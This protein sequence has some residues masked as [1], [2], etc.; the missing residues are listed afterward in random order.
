MDGQNLLQGGGAGRRGE[1]SSSWGLGAGRGEEVTSCLGRLWGLASFNLTPGIR[2]GVGRM[3]M[4]HPPVNSRRQILL[5]GWAT[6]SF[7]DPPSATRGWAPAQGKREK[8]QLL[9]LGA[10]SYLSFYFTAISPKIRHSIWWNHIDK[11]LAV[12]KKMLWTPRK[13]KSRS[14]NTFFFIVSC[15]ILFYFC[16]DKAQIPRPCWMKVKR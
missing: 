14:P 6:A 11:I 2:G 4:S 1:D 12:I 3:G 15:C 7:T 5:P 10:Q 9:C 16:Q 8:C 13:S